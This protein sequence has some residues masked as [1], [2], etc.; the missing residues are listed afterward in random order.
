LTYTVSYGPAARAD[1]LKIYDYIAEH[2]ST[3]RALRYLQRIEATCET[4][5]TFPERGTRRDAIKKGT[6]II[7]F[8]KRVAIVYSVGKR[9]ITVARVLYGG[10]HLK[11]AVKNL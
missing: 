8:E 4:L 10:R 5:K 7:G 1:M 3:E 9:K 11:R 2:S 6:R